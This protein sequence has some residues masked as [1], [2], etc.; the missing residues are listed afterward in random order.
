MKRYLTLIIVI[1]IIVIVGILRIPTILLT[2]ILTPSVD[3]VEVIEY[4]KLDDVNLDWG[5]V[6]IYDVIINE[7][8]PNKMNVNKAAFE[9]LIVDYEEFEK[10][11][12]CSEKDENGNCIDFNYRWVKVF[13]DRYIGKEVNNLL[14]KL[15]YKSQN[16]II[17]TI[18]ILKGAN[19]LEKHNITISYKDIHD[20]IKHLP[21]EQQEYAEFLLSDN[22]IYEMYQEQFD[23]PEN[24]PVLTNDFFA[25]PVPNLHTITS[26]Y[27]WRY[28]PIK[29]KNVFHYGIDISGPNAMGQPIIAS[30]DGEVFQVNY[31]NGESGYNVRIKHFDNEG[32]VWQTRYCHMSSIIVKVG[33]KVKQ[34]DVIG[35]VGNTGLSTGP[36]LHF[37]IKFNGMY[38]DPYKY[39]K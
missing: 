14:K 9:F 38:V 35:A 20:L 10:E 11:I 37:E 12:Y 3:N 34:G 39:I 2:V 16:N 29:M 33:D 27:G 1:L 24:I 4:K 32:N 15:G 13:E 19:E 7:N 5:E 28:H 31:S 21:V 17:N 26:F 18:E 25:Y 8:N 6:L 23:L 22:A 30:A 36:H